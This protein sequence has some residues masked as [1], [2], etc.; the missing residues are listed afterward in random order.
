[1]RNKYLKNSEGAITEKEIGN[2]KHNKMQK[3]KNEG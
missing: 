2:A 1:M 3:L